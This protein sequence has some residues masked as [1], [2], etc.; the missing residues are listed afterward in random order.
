MTDRPDQ[1]TLREGLGVLA[2]AMRNEP[3]VFAVAVAGSAVYGSTTALTAVVVGRVTDDVVVPA[4]D[5]GRT[6]A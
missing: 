5:E 4:F 1:V 6:T 2:R 3:R